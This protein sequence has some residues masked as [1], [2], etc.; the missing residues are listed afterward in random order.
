MEQEVELPSGMRGR[1]RA[2]KVKDERVWTDA[3]IARSG[4]LIEEL[5]KRCWLIKIRIASRGVKYK[6][7]I[8][9]DSCRSKIDWVID[10]EDDLMYLPLLPDVRE[11]FVNDEPL[12]TKLEDGRQIQHRLIQVGDHKKLRNLQDTRGF[13]QLN[14]ALTVRLQSVE[15]VGDHPHELIRF[16]EELDSGEADDIRD[17]LEQLDCGIDTDID[18]TCDN[19][20]YQF[21]TMLP[22]EASF[23]KEPSSRSK[24]KRRSNRQKMNPDSQLD[25]SSG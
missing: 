20:F 8:P 14:A 23:F 12:I 17:Q 19:C 1:I 24:K 7:S 22:F 4:R 10:L 18:V 2:L 6:F 9:C 11:R 15:G 25:E 16:V 21:E 3:K 5:C 13:S